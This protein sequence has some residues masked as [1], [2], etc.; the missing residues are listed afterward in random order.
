MSP[1]KM[2]IAPDVVEILARS[3][4]AGN[5][6]TLPEQLDRDTYLRV[7]KA[8]KAARGKWDR[9]AKGHVFPFDP[10]ELIA[11]AV[12]EGAVVNAKQ[13][14]GFFETPDALAKRMVD[15]AK[16]GPD[17]RALEPSAGLGQ[18]V[19]HLLA[20]GA[21]VDAV[22]V[23]A[24]N[25][26]ALR[27]IGGDLSVCN[28]PFETFA[29]VDATR[30]DAA[31]MNPPFANNQ[32]IQHM[33]LAWDMLRPSGRLVAICSE[34]PFFRQDAAATEFRAWLD[35]IGASAEK[36]PPDTFPESGTGV[37]ARLIVATREGSRT[38]DAPPEV[39]VRNIPVHQIA[40][41][42]G[43][44]RK[45]FDRAALGELAASIR[46]DG[47][48]QPITIRPAPPGSLTPYLIVTGERRFRAC[49]I[50]GAATI[51][52]IVIEPPDQADVR[53]KQIIENDQRQDVTPLEQ[54]RSYQTL[55]DET[56]WSV[57]QLAA[58]L[59]KAP[60]RITERTVL[61]TLRPEYQDLLA[62]GNLKPSEATELARLSP[63]GQGVLFNA[64]RTGGCRNYNDLRAS[65]NALVQAEAQ[66]TLMPD[67]PPPPCEEDRRLA[68]TFE[69]NVE[70]VAALLRTG[71]HENQ[72]VAVRK[73]NPDRATYLADLLGAM[74]KDL[75]RI[76]VALREAA[77]QASFLS[78]A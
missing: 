6:L 78:A 11:G 24:T 61:L 14:L 12:D 45:T 66:L 65:A 22:E 26:K 17:D 4:I 70:R 19:R 23:D 48:L 39:A 60:W 38:T 35:E 31:V 52:A 21:M 1:V 33:R 67:A 40:P 68:S 49:R 20:T 29:A 63:R 55:M 47:L 44:P 53:V 72:V 25:C 64:I 3:T 42:P 34:G 43:Q 27:Q 71:I 50:N 30:F 76:E 77:V 69:A 54:A 74:Q 10:R 41:D 62:S 46:A 18:I 37:A 15:L 28:E 16:L 2:K 13:T 73:T 36:L 75:R 56:G 8:L 32:D 7:D 59:G 5:V 58:R 51:R 9:K 57:E